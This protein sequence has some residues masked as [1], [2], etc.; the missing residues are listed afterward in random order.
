MINSINLI[1]NWNSG[2]G[3]DKMDVFTNVGEWNC[4]SKLCGDT[5][6]NYGLK[7]EALA[8]VIQSSDCVNIYSRTSNSTHGTRLKIKCRENGGWEKQTASELAN[9]I[10]TGTV[11]TVRKLFHLFPVRARAVNR[12]C[13]LNML[14]EFLK[15]MCILHH[16]VSWLLVESDLEGDDRPVNNRVVCKYEASESVPGSFAAV[17]GEVARS[18]MKV[19]YSVISRGFLL[20]C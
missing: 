4:T 16:K 6:A 15:K 14:K 9:D 1:H 20:L 7:G 8:A 5:S 13:E 3:I 10:F 18:A 19:C 12:V 2:C 11:V 17:H